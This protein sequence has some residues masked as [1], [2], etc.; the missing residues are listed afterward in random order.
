MCSSAFFF[1]FFTRCATVDKITKYCISWVLVSGNNRLCFQKVFSFY[2][3]NLL[4]KIAFMIDPLIISTQLLI[5]IIIFYCELERSDSTHVVVHRDL[6]TRYRFIERKVN[7]VTVD[8]VIC[9]FMFNWLL[10]GTD[11]SV[12]VRLQKCYL[13][14]FFFFFFCWDQTFLFFVEKCKFKQETH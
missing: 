1:F 12:R 14:F 5:I 13:L 11:V 6:K 9:S 3:P 7:V 8:T 10:T 4:K 2:G